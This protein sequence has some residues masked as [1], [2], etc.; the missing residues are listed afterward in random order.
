MT[1]ACTAARDSE[2]MSPFSVNPG[3]LK[4]T[5]SSIIPGATYLPK[6]STSCD[7]SQSIEE[8][9]FSIRSSLIAISTV[10]IS[11]SLIRLQFFK[12]RLAFIY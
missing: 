8:A 3:S 4:C 7:A 10:F 12:T 11:S 6:Q 1:P 2:R 9:I 5:W